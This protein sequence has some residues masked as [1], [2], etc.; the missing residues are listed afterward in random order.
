MLVSFSG[1][2]KWG[3]YTGL[4]GP[5][6]KV[7]GVFELQYDERVMMELKGQVFTDILAPLY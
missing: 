2:G 5:L 7:S 4:Y 6:I 3:D 1:Y